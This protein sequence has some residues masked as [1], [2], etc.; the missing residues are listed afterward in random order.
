[1]AVCVYKVRITI[2]QCMSIRE[3]AGVAIYWLF[4]AQEREHLTSFVPKC[5]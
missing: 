2:Y 4:A 3:C 1:M 5:K